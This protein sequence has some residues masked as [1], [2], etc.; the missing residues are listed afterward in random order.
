MRA[1]RRRHEASPTDAEQGI[2][3]EQRQEIEALPPW[4]VRLS[5]K[6][7]ETGLPA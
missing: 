1:A 5:S 3:P 2:A 4:L 7:S 6:L